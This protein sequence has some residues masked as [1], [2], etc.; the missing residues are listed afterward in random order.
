MTLVGTKLTEL[1][2]RRWRLHTC[3]CHLQLR[4][5]WLGVPTSEFHADRGK[6]PNA[7]QE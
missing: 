4:R 1:V 6:R 2:Q 3:C 5:E 7:E